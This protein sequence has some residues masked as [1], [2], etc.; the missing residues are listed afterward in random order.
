MRHNLFFSCLLFV[1]VGFSACTSSV[2]TVE[3]LQVELK[4]NPVGIETIQPRF[5]W[6]AVSKSRN[7]RQSAY[8]IVV[9]TSQLNLKKGKYDVWNSGVVN[10]QESNL[11]SFE[12]ASLQ[13][14]TTYFWKVKIRDTQNNESPWSQPAKFTS[15]LLTDA[16]WEKAK[17]IALD[18]LPASKRIVPGIHNPKGSK[19][20]RDVKTAGHKL[21]IFRKGMKVSKTVESAT[22]FISGL[23][24]YEAFL[25]GDKIGKSVMAPGWTDYDSYCLYN[26]YDV[27]H[28]IDK[29]DNVI[30]VMLGNGFYNVPNE[31]Y[32]KIITVF[33]N[34]KLIAKLQLNYTDGSRDVVVT[35]NT[36]KV[37]ESPITFSSIYSGE[38]FDANL[39]PEGWKKS[40]FDDSNWRAPIIVDGPQGELV[41]SS[42]YPVEVME[43]LHPKNIYQVE[44]ESGGGY[45][46]DFGQN[47]S[48]VISVQLKGNRGDTVYFYPGELIDKNG[49]LLQGATGRPFYFTYILKGDG[50]ETWQPQFTYYGFRYVSVLG[51]RPDTVTASG[52]EPAIQYLSMQHI[53][54]SMPEVGT[55]STDH[56]MFNRVNELIRWAMK[57]NLMS[58][59]TDCPHR[60]KLGWMEQTHLMGP[61]IHYNFDLYHL[62]SKLVRDMMN[63]QTDEGMVPDIAP[64]YVEFWD[65][66]RDSPEWGS[67][68]VALPYL[69]YKWYGD[70]TIMERAWSMMERYALYLESRSDNHIVSHGLGDWYDLGPNRPGF[71]Q[72][73]PEAL[74]ATAIYYYDVKILAE[75]ALV[76]GKSADHQKYFDWAESIKKA[77]NQKF[78]DDNTGIYSTGSQTAQAMPLVIGLVEEGMQDKVFQ[79]LL[80]TIEKDEKALTTGDVGFFYLVKALQDGGASE[81]LFEM[82]NRDDVPGYGYQLKMGATALTESWQALDLVSNNH[83][84]LGHIMQWFYAGLGGIDQSVKS[85]GYSEAVIQ[86]QMVS[87]INEVSASRNSPYGEIKSSWNRNKKSAYF[88]VSIPFNSSALIYFPYQNG[89]VISEGNQPVDEVKEIEVIGVEDGLFKMRIGSGDYRFEIK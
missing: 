1:F 89:Q 78:L 55:F 74:T 70:K 20:W 47:A 21:P 59:V 46:Y 18:S 27:T 8:H 87:G 13:S 76:L 64:E 77:F 16:D 33:G 56:T 69:L 73:T 5:S 60:E 57:S 88:E 84:M 39:E 28:M 83:L 32:R 79:Q 25:N 68:S 65:G 24:H 35:D 10:S 34:P 4:E 71:A 36:W 14:G 15:A 63:S 58:V 31:R 82:N 40:G 54:N 7:N 61:S 22:L 85:I 53:R 86:P 44:K 45:L 42:D 50:V 11:I 38:T 43:T 29:G 6:K 9:S 41:A 26:S 72:L 51:A 12:G 62:Y 30:S 81:L 66:F 3:T 49:R 80:N 2:L 37:A 17:W 19:E 67:A 52:S 75:M 48:G 23:G